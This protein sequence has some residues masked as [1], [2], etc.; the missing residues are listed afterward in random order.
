M[1]R[2]EIGDS[3]IT[4]GADSE[5]HTLLGGTIDINYQLVARTKNIVLG[6]GNI[7]LWLERE[8]L[9]IKYVAAKYFLT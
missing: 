5:L 1:H 3:D 6:G 8:T 4:I 9:V 2:T 7:H